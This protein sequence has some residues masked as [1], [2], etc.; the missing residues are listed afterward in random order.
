VQWFATRQLL[1]AETPVWVCTFQI[2]LDSVRACMVA[3]IFSDWT[4]ARE[5][6]PPMDQSSMDIWS[7]TCY[8]QF[9]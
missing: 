7:S 8:Q 2:V 6:V 4:G 1:Q 3:L 5:D 9:C